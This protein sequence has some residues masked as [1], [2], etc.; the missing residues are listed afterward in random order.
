MDD[1][2][3]EN[4]LL[5]QSLWNC[6]LIFFIKTHYGVGFGAGHGS[7]FFLVQFII[8]AKTKQTRPVTG[9]VTYI[10]FQIYVTSGTNNAW[11]C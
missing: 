9:V 8:G 4:I 11:V 1:V 5:L 2:A 3:S 6:E 7:Y 10:F